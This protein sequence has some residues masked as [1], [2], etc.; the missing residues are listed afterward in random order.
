MQADV[1]RVISSGPDWFTLTGQE[2][3]HT[4]A[5]EQVFHSY[6][7][8]DNPRPIELQKWVWTGYRG[9]AYKGMH[10]GIRN[11]DEAAL[12]VA[13]E[14]A[15]IVLPSDLPTEIRCT[16]TDVQVSVHLDRPRPTFAMLLYH[17]LQAKQ[18]DREK[19]TYYKLLQSNS[20]DTLYVNKRTSPV[21]LRLYDKSLD[22]GHSHL[23]TVWR[24]EVEFKRPKAQAVYDEW[25][26][27]TDVLDWS[28]GRVALEFETRGIGSNW[29]VGSLPT[30]I[31]VRTE[32]KTATSK[33]AWLVRCVRPVVVELIANGYEEQ[34]ISSIY[35]EPAK[36]GSKEK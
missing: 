3:I 1:A 21:M 35:A 2:K 20:G 32:V 10:Y 9:F 33:L 14:L 34:V 26:S 27:S 30:A 36:N 13:G 11:D 22:Y 4:S 31:E 28:L 18:A 24:Y 16:R 7:K 19:K 15:R 17:D 29:W 23:G 12:V 25:R 6:V 8:A 5:L